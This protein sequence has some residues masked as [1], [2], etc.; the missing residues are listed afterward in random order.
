MENKDM[1]EL[2]NQELELVNGGGDALFLEVQNIIASKLGVVK[3]SINLQSKI[4][5]DLGADSLDVVDVLQAVALKYDVKELR[6]YKE[7]KSVA[8]IC[9]LARPKDSRNL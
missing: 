4:V 9:K 8:D 1:K 2:S 3:S 7:Y 6:P 5:E